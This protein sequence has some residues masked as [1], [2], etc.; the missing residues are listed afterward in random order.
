MDRSLIT[1]HKGWGIYVDNNTGLYIIKK[2]DLFWD[3][4]G[5]ANH[6]NNIDIIKSEINKTEKEA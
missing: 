2:G 1:T 5:G 3:F 6:Q 4:L